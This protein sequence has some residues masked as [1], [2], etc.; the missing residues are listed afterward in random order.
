M[1]HGLV[2][3]REAPADEFATLSCH[4]STILVAALL[5][6]MRRLHGGLR[7]SS[8]VCERVYLEAA[9]TAANTQREP[10]DQHARLATIDTFTTSQCS[11]AACLVTALV[12]A[13]LIT[14][15]LITVPTTA[16]ASTASICAVACLAAT[17]I[18]A[19][20]AA[21]RTAPIDTQVPDELST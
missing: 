13:T 1:Q 6:V 18:A 19:I 12:T 9:P 17:F 3:H 7:R 15:T 21:A 5:A 20:T 11:T 14:A 4:V 10:H 16:A 8:D 2:G